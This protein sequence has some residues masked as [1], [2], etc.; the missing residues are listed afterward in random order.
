MSFR[1]NLK[2]KQMWYQ[3]KSYIKF[4]WKSTNRHGIH[5]PFVYDLVTKCFN[6]NIK[7]QQYD[8][9]N[10]F[11]RMALQSK[12]NIHVKDFGAGSRVFTSN[13][14]PI[15]KIARHTGI[16][17]KRQKLLFRLIK[18]FEPETILE[19]GTSLG[20]ATIAMSLGNRSGKVISVEGCPNTL[21]TA[22][23][24]FEVFDLTNIV[25][26]ECTFD[27]YFRNS[28]NDSYDLVY[29]DG[30]HDYTNT[31]QYFNKLLKKVTNNSI[32]IFDD[33]YWSP[34]MTRAWQ[35]ICSHPDVRVSIDIFYWGIVFLGA[36]R[37]KNIL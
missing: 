32:L 27:S 31:M 24:F 26:Q 35:D 23:E 3:I 8:R 14:R 15:S 29:I 1:I 33:I 36:N 5:S 21:K 13:I 7:Y 12:N 11:R 34:S 20:I 22:N 37:K 25:P 28:N 4:L 6:D 10:E 16:S 30:N 9:L 19:L 17:Q 18:Y 2:H